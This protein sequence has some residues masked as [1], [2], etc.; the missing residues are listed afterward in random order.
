MLEL[1]TKTGSHD[2]VTGANCEKAQ[3]HRGGTAL[4]K[5]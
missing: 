1:E 2:L 4:Q 5:Q 3:H